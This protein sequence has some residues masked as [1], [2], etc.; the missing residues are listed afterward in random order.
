MFCHVVSPLN[1]PN[2]SG[3]RTWS[4]SASPCPSSGKHAQQLVLPPDYRAR[5]SFTQILS[6]II[7]FLMPS[8]QLPI[9]NSFHRLGVLA[10]QLSQ[11]STSLLH[12][13]GW[14]ACMQNS[15]IFPSQESPLS[16]HISF[17][18]PWGS[19]ASAVLLT[20]PLEQSLSSMMML[21]NY[22]KLSVFSIL[23]PSI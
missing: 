17:L 11:R 21:L 18:F 8:P 20:V 9:N 16:L 4:L 14:R 6:M 5:D 10:W 3:Q 12:R 2:L 7:S 13:A 19:G 23:Q 22:T 15:F 1:R